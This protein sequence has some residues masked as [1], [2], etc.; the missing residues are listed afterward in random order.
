M[1]VIPAIDLLAGAPVR[2]VQGR[3]DRVLRTVAGPLQLAQEHAAQG[4][5]WLHV[6]DLDGAR[7]GH[8]CNLDLIAEIVREVGLP[9]Q[10]GG[11]ARDRAAVA[12]ALKAG[13]RRVIVSTAVLDRPELLT[14]LAAEFADQLV[15]GLD[16]RRGHLLAEG[17]SRE[18]GQDLLETASR[19]IESGAR[20]VIYTDTQRDGT[21][22]GGDHG[23]VTE[24]VKLGVPVLAAGGISSLQDL[25][26]IRD[27]G[28]EAA[29]VGRA[30][31]GG[32]LNLA[33]A[34]ATA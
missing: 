33:D 31:F 14:S 1:L 6:I 9:V 11:G 8:W 25:G 29:V 10:A 20:R 21:L 16:A 28:A 22:A 27:A 15:I 32:S 4:A 7:A 26:L 34:I 18:T 23:G 3:Y 17:W 30:I 2:L 13:V 19:A 24:L 12:A 5:T